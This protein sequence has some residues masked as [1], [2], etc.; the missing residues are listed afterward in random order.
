MPKM[1]SFRNENETLCEAP[2]Y[3]GARLDGGYSTHII[4]PHERYLVPYGD[5]NPFQAAPY[6]CS[7]LT[8][9]AL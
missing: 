9:L 2:K 6:A 1:F 8:A 5:L 7:G 4:V 3:L